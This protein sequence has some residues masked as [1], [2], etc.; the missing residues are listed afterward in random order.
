MYVC[1]YIYTHIYVYT[2]YMS[3]P[4]SVLCCDTTPLQLNSCWLGQVNFPTG[5]P[6]MGL[7]QST[8]Q[9]SDLACGEDEVNRS[10]ACVQKV[11]DFRPS[12]SLKLCCKNPMVTLGHGMAMLCTSYIIRVQLYL[13]HQALYISQV[14]L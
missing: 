3:A 14:Y 9:A 12:A 1:V 5:L 7:R 4:L 8:Q 10:Q 11:P 13:G 6:T 2:Q